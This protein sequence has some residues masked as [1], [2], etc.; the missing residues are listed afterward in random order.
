MY[1]PQAAQICYCRIFPG[2]PGVDTLLCYCRVAHESIITNQCAHSRT[3][4]KCYD[5]RSEHLGMGTLV[6]YCRDAH[7]LGHSHS[8]FFM[9]MISHSAP[10][11]APFS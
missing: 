9:M 5:N 4:E 10:G 6:C 7:M 1:T 3:H 8:I 2:N 11:A